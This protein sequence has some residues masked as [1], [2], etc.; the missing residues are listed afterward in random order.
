MDF[1]ILFLAAYGLCF[2]LMNGKAKLLTN[3]LLLL[4]LFI[5]ENERGQP[6]T[7]FERMLVCPYCTGFHT[8]WMAW[9]LIRFPGYMFRPD[10]LSVAL[11][12]VIATA[13]ASAAVC[14]LLDTFAQWAEDTSVA[15]SRAT[16]DE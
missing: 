9:M 11:P 10:Q 7:F 13:F 12:E 8:G 6:T 16:Q 4:P 2:G 1:L 5:R 14:Y 3:R 15:A